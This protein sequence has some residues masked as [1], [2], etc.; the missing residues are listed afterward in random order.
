M[1][2][3]PKGG[4]TENVK[5][6]F[7]VE[8]FLIITLFFSETKKYLGSGIKAVASKVLPPIQ[9]LIRDLEKCCGTPG[10][11]RTFCLRIRRIYLYIWYQL[12]GLTHC[13]SSMCPSAATCYALPTPNHDLSFEPHFFRRMA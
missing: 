1:K 10:K 7:L 2:Q 6:L 12:G 4:T 9:R 5:K 8:Y 13:L 3:N 11:I